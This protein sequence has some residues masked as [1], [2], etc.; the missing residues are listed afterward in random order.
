M[1]F[2]VFHIREKLIPCDVLEFKDKVETFN[3]EPSGNKVASR[4][5][6]LHVLRVLPYQIDA[7]FAILRVL[8][9]SLPFFV[10]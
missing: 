3:W 6:G 9:H 1:N 7:L 8:M 2:E 10:F 4:L 5:C